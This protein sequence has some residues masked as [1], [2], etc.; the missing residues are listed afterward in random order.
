MD[1]A[2][3]AS[4][5]QPKYA[6]VARV[7]Q[8]AQHL[9]HLAIFC[10]TRTAASESPRCCISTPTTI[11]I[12][13]IHTIVLPDCHGDRC[14]THE[15]PAA[16]LTPGHSHCID[17]CALRYRHRRRGSRIDW[18]GDILRQRLLFRAS[19]P[20]VARHIR[21]YALDV[22]RSHILPCSYL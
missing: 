5:S 3:E 11:L 1:N 15:V 14:F 9:G 17:R 2:N 16:I 20:T 10:T 19:A 18:N 21:D 22:E 12:N 13:A 4:G 8:K 7:S 6:S